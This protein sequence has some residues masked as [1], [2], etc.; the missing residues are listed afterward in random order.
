[1]KIS[2]RKLKSLILKEAFDFGLTE[3]VKEYLKS[4]ARGILKSKFQIH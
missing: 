1:M 4:T 2:K 3:K